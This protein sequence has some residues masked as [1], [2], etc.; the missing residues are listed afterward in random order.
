MWRT[1]TY[2]RRA[3]RLRGGED[4]ILSSCG[5]PQS[6]PFFLFARGYLQTDLDYQ[7]GAG[8]DPNDT[9][10]VALPRNLLGGFCK[11][12]PLMDLGKELK[13][14]GSMPNK[15]DYIKA[16]D[17]IVRFCCR[18][19]WAALSSMA[20]RD[21]DLNNDGVLDRDEI[22]ELMTL[23]LGEEPTS[24]MLD[25]MMNSVDENS[26]GVIDEDEFTQ[27]MAN[28]KRSTGHGLN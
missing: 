22:R 24:V 23:K 13:E 16:I 10:V 21:M 25:L 2:L 1:D 12:K 9:L 14:K 18:E 8:G 15:D 11:I 3:R 26:N 28:L 19:R 6:N 5:S 7:N 4:A 27:L 20:F 17:I